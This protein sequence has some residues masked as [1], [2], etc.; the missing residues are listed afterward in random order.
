MLGHSKG[1]TALDRG[2]GTEARIE[3]SGS[4]HPVP[5]QAEILDDIGL[6]LATVLGLA[7]VVNAALSVGIGG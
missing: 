7:A 1:E 3:D 5:T 2:R 4:V 6:L